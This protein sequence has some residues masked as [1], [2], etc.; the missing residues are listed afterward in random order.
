MFVAGKTKIGSQEILPKQ[1]TSLLLDAQERAR[2]RL[3]ALR[4]VNHSKQKKKNSAIR[5]IVLD[6]NALDAVAKV[7]NESFE[8]KGKGHFECI[9]IGIALAKTQDIFESDLHYFPI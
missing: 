7:E 4:S 6:F 5:R 3:E 8:S 9:G 1:L 2:N